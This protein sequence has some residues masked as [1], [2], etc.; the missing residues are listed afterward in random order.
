MLA[1]VLSQCTTLAFLSLDGNQIG[2]EGAAMLAGALP[3]C[4]RL[5]NIYLGANRIGAQGAV[6]CE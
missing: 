5:S 3:H 2:D 4:R 6:R 1:E